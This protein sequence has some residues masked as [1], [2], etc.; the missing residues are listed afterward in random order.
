MR[1]AV[2]HTGILEIDNSDVVE[3]VNDD[4]GTFDILVE[5][6]YRIQ[7]RE[8]RGDLNNPAPFGRAL[9]IEMAC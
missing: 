5:E 8:R 1:P 4:I 3:F 6:V 7:L 2:S 9:G